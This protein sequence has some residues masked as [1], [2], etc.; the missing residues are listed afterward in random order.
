[1]NVSRGRRRRK[2]EEEEEFF[3]HYK[4]DLKRHAHTLSGVA[5]AD[6]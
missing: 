5:G 6:L 2:E 3:N 1:M 4:T